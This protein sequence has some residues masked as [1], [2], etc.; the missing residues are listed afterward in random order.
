MSVF[1]QYCQGPL[2]VMCTGGAGGQAADWTAGPET[3]CA[4]VQTCGGGHQD[5]G[6][7]GDGQR[8]CSHNFTM[9]CE[10]QATC[11]THR[12][13]AEEPQ[14]RATH[15]LNCKRQDWTY[16][17]TCGHW[18]TCAVSCGIHTLCGAGQQTCAPAE[19]TV[20]VGTGCVGR[21]TRWPH[22]EPPWS[23]GPVTQ[24][25]TVQTCGATC[26]PGCHGRAGSSGAADEAPGRY[27]G[28]PTAYPTCDG[29]QTCGACPPVVSR[30][31]LTQCAG[32]QTC[33][34][35]CAPGCGWTQGAQC[36]GGQAAA[37]PV[38]YG[39]VTQCAGVQTCGACPPM[40]SRGPITQCAGVQT[41]GETC[42]PGCG[43]TRGP[44]CYGGQAAEQ[45]VSYGPVT[46][47]AGVQTCGEACGPVLT[48]GPLTAC[49][50][51]QTC[52]PDCYQVTF[53]CG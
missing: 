5:A 34:E 48:Q 30:G 22:C 36:Y 20:G 40:V 47:C 38:S 24:C 29:W 3:H 23:A 8:Y 25:L 15:S 28:G 13:F 4:G 52:G 1:T 19:P 16:F 12:C 10:T 9:H 44:Q 39:P 49:G 2:T 35:T 14:L 31:P 33:G 50:G 37:Q 7:T 26:A 32:V 11:R 46:Q 53:A 21:Q 27:Q 17:R 51:V 45:P 43:W 42:A 6:R 41:C 18:M